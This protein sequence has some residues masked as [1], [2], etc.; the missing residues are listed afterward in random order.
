MHTTYPVWYG[1]LHTFRVPADARLQ[2]EDNDLGLLVER[3]LDGAQLPAVAVG[4]E[5]LWGDRRPD[6]KSYTHE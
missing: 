3:H 1:D 5:H 2:P 4:H 6:L